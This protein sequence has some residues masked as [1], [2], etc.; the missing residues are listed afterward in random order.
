M[1]FSWLSFGKPCC[2][3]ATRWPKSLTFST[4]TFWRGICWTSVSL[5][6]TGNLKTILHHFTRVCWADHHH[7]DIVFVWE[8]SNKIKRA[9]CGWLSYAP[10]WDLRAAVKVLSHLHL[11]CPSSTWMHEMNRRISVG[12]LLLCS[13]LHKCWTLKQY[14]FPRWCNFHVGTRG[15]GL[16][17]VCHCP[18]ANLRMSCWG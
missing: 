10:T 17:A 11:W 6:L 4:F 15:W 2:A 5:L 7:F 1:N 12:M 13:V 16:S 9:Q 3:F 8:Y 18:P 14:N